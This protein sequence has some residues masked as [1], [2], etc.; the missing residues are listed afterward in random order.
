MRLKSIENNL[1]IKQ[2]KLIKP[3]YKRKALKRKINNILP[4]KLNAS[5]KKTS[6]PPE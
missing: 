3:N 1:K 5:L 2:E 6:L 4:Y